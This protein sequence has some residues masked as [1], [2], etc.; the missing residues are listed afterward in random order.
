MRW[1]YTRRW[2][3]RAFQTKLS[4]VDTEDIHCNIGRGDL[5]KKSK[6]LFPKCGRNAIEIHSK[7]KSSPNEIEIYIK[8]NARGT[9]ERERGSNSHEIRVK[10]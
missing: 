7:C 3:E 10:S 9:E 2:E 8:F 6:N 5:G 1:V 4:E